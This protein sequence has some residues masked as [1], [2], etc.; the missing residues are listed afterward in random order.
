[1]VGI[2]K[3][4]IAVNLQVTFDIHTYSLE[5]VYLIREQNFVKPFAVYKYHHQSTSL[6][7][8]VELWSL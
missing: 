3:I 7:L 1:M 4:K 2:S 8:G 6:F 5:L